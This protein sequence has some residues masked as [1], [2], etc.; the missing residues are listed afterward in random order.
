[1]KSFIEYVTPMC[2]EMSKEMQVSPEIL[3]SAAL[4]SRKEIEKYVCQAMADKFVFEHGAKAKPEAKAEV[5][6][7]KAKAQPQPQPQPELEAEAEPE[8]EAEAP[9]EA[10]AA[11]EK[12][13]EHKPVVLPVA[14]DA[15]D[16]NHKTA[17]KNGLLAV[18]GVEASAIKDNANLSR[19]AKDLVKNSVGKEIFVS[20]TSGLDLADSVKAEIKGW[21]F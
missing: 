16:E 5:K 2:E 6:P 21:K 13:V 8:A 18:L 7:T 4:L 9:V 15:K 3:L 20:T 11:K 14:F 17:F 10:P 12:P 19:L 1:M